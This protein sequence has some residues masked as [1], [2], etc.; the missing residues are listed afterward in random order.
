MTLQELD[1]RL[2][3]FQVFTRHFNEIGNDGWTK[4]R[5]E[6]L[7]AIEEYA[8]EREHQAK[9]DE[10]DYHW[11]RQKHIERTARSGRISSYFLDRKAE[12]QQQSNGGKHE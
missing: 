1:K 3:N 5:Q 9:I 6:M 7:E 8:S 4:S 10:N 12:L 2:E 11:H